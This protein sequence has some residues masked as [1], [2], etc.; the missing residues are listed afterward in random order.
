MG[1]DAE[2]SHLWKLEPNVSLVKKDE[3]EDDGERCRDGFDGSH[4]PVD[5]VEVLF[6]ES[7]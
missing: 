6:W 3:G 5:G 4:P 1:E 2:D 7:R